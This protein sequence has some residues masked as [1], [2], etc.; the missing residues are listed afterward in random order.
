MKNVNKQPQSQHHIDNIYNIENLLYILAGVHDMEHLGIIVAPQL[1]DI[2]E[3]NV[4][5]PVLRSRSHKEPPI[6]VGA[7]AGAVTRCDSGSDGSG[8]DNGIKHG[9]EL[10]IDTKCNS[11]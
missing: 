6:L 3:Y 11:L 7:G 2:W 9:W 1:Y 5:N 8:S 4:Y 10:K